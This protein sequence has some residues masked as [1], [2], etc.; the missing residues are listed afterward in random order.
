MVIGL[1]TVQIT[2]NTGKIIA[3]FNTNVN[4]GETSIPFDLS[5]NTS[6]VYF[7]KINLNNE[8]IIKKINKL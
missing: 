3:E 4:N 5:S 6:G 2:E 8:I 7:L 1:I